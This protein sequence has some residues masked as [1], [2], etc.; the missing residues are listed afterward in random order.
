MHRVF[1]FGRSG[2]HQ[3]ARL[4]VVARCFSAGAGLGPGHT[5][6]PRPSTWAGLSKTFS[7]TMRHLTIQIG[8][9]EAVWLE[10]FGPV[11]PAFSADPG[12]PLDRR[13]PSAHQVTSGLRP[14]MGLG[15]NSGWVPSD[16]YR[17]KN[18]INLHLSISLTS[19]L[20]SSL[21]S[22]KI[23]TAKIFTDQYC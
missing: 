23:Y 18:F 22:L 13:G 15:D 21:G 14:S 16:L 7:P 10:I 8:Y 17:V 6:S 11:F 5:W 20:F 12:T 9:L 1:K 2:H 19:D 3:R 4:F